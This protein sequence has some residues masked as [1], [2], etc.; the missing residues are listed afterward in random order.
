MKKLVYFSFLY[1]LAVLSSCSTGD[2]PGEAFIERLVPYGHWQ[3]IG[4]VENGKLNEYINFNNVSR[5]LILR[6]DSTFQATAL[7]YEFSGKYEFN[8]DRYSIKFPSNNNFYT[9]YSAEKEEDQRYINLLLKVDT[10]KVIHPDQL[11]LYYSDENYLQYKA[12]P[13]NQP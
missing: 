3:A 8:V 4:F 2:M 5:Q 1:L 6:K 11:R 13:Q 12:V 7:N 9:A 10:Y